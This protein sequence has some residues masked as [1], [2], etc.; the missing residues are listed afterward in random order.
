MSEFDCF[1]RPATYAAH[2]HD[3]RSDLLFSFRI[4]GIND[5]PG[6]PI[7][8]LQPSISFAERIYSEFHEHLSALRKLFPY[9]VNFCFRFTSDMERYRWIELKK[10][11]GADCLEFQT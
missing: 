10:R 6:K 8:I 5:L 7:L 2:E 4:A 9:F 3:H 1:F 11:A